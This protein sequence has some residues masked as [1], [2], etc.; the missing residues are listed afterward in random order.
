MERNGNQEFKT[1]ERKG[2]FMIIKKSC[3][4]KRNNSLNKLLAFNS[5]QRESHFT[6]VKLFNL[7][8]GKFIDLLDLGICL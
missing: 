7:V 6:F 5:F 3:P 8:G 1:I 2:Q 4:K